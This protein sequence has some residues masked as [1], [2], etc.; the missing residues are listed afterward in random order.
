MDDPTCWAPWA[1][2]SLTPTTLRSHC[3][4]LILQVGKLRHQ[5][6][7]HTGFC[8]K[9][10]VQSKSAPNSVHTQMGPPH[11]LPVFL[12]GHTGSITWILSPHPRRV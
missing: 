4:Y 3:Y 2:G 8:L 6:A 11:L 1:A 10:G 5:R 12:S 9:A 7:D